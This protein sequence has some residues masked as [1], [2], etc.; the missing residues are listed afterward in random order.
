MNVRTAI[1]LSLLDAAK[2]TSILFW[3][4][5]FQRALSWNREQVKAYQARQL[6]KLIRHAR[7]TVPYY[8]EEFRRLGVAPEDIN[9]AAA[10]SSLP[11]LDREVIQDNREALLSSQYAAGNLH[12]GSSSGTTGIPIH[13]YSDPSGLSA[14]T[15]AGYVLWN[16]SGW[17]PG[18]RH[19][20]I[21][22]NETSIRRWK[23]IGSKM[24]NLLFRQKN[25]PSTLLD[26]PANLAGIARQI[27]RFKPRSIEGYASSIY[28]LAVYF[29]QEGLHLDNLKQVL[30]TAENLAPY[31]KSLIEQVFAP[32]GDLYGTGEVLGIASRPA[33]GQRY[34]IMDPHVVA[35]TAE[36]GINGMKSLLVTDLNN[37]GM[38]L[39]RY[40][41]GDLVDELHEPE[42]EAE[43]PFTW[44]TRIL[45]R[46]SE[47]ITLPNGK[48]FHPVNIFGGTFF[49]NFPQV[50]K[51]KVVWDGEALKFFFE[52]RERPPAPEMEAGLK[53]LL[54]SFDVPFSVE[55]TH[56]ILPSANGKFKYFEIAK[57]EGAVP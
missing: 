19:V 45:G 38:P 5:F 34:F 3:Y 53:S 57:K 54:Q 36:T 50:I 1:L 49:R 10:L 56:K 15:A 25:I 12:K 22:G 30:T 32:A 27:I 17:E 41:I 18:R 24:K 13:Y 44:F 26:G 33:G 31:Q 6:H 51:H 7:D 14:G 48:R 55:Y 29:Q 52:V 37:F 40:R 42:P 4:R 35:E 16:M 21:W 46:S 20:H 23:T 8:R 28:S 43:F 2:G 9:S 11:I 39:I 47:I